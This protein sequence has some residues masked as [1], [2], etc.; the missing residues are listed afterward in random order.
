MNARKRRDNMLGAGLKI[1]EV[2]EGKC[3]VNQV[4]DLYF[5]Q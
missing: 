2:N 1:A 4:E 5:P 3:R